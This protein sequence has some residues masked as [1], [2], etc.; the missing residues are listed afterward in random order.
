M[1]LF[2]N[3]N[4]II[5][6]SST[7]YTTHDEEEDSQVGLTG[8][9]L[10][11]QYALYCLPLHTVDRAAPADRTSMMLPKRITVVEV[12]PRDGFQ[13]EKQFIPTEK[14]VEII[15]ALLAAGV[16]RLETTAFVSAKVIP[17]LRDAAE[18]MQGVD[19]PPGVTHV[20]L[21][22]NRK[23]A[24]RAAAAGV[25]SMKIVIAATD[26]YNRRNVGMTVEESLQSAADC[27]AVARENSVGMEGVIGLSFGC[28]LTGD[29]PVETLI[30]IARR[31]VEAGYR[32][33]SLA[34]SFGL[35]NP[36]QVR[37]MLKR[38]REEFPDVHWSLHIHNT[39]GLGLANVVAAMEEGVDMF[40]S[41]LGGLG[42]SEVA[43]A[44]ATGNIPTEDLVNMLHEMEIETGIDLD[45]LTKASRIAQEFLGRPLPSYILAS[46]TR[47]QYYQESQKKGAPRPAGP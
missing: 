5:S 38:M 33:L 41:S 22:P 29:V 24:E 44:G 46:G 26:A 3:S 18:V 20:A 16:R 19:R 7:S 27:N 40:D 43:V 10:P 30:H 34:D 6:P 25:D 4:A 11:V 15:N 2:Q 32:E 23:G 47:E 28:P 31:L 17:Q 37:R 14:K 13:F 9:I 35:A 21:I 36:L 42:G 45:G 12:G 1:Q 8:P 39:R